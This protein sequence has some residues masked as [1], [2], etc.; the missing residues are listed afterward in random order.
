M[1]EQALEYADVA[2]MFRRRKW[3][4]AIPTFF[5]LSIAGAL[6]YLLPSIYVSTATILI[7]QQDVPHSQVASTVS[8]YAAE[9]IQMVQSKVMTSDN[10]WTIA[11]VVDL[12]PEQRSPEAA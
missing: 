1:S 5:V 8:G 2:S 10:L 11:V 12:Y 4:F 6:A 3:H 9:R 7:E